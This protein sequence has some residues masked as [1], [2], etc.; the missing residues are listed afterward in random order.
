MTDANDALKAL[1]E[2]LQDIRTLRE[3]A[4]QSGVAYK[5]G[6]AATALELAIAALSR[7]AWQKCS[8]CEHVA[9]LCSDYAKNLYA[10]PADKDTP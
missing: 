8:R 10:P 6:K 2:G 9:Q 4:G 5:L 7:S 3:N 1:E